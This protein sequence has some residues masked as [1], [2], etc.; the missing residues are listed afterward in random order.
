VLC[1]HPFS[2]VSATVDFDIVNM[3]STPRKVKNPLLTAAGPGF[4]FDNYTENALLMPVTPATPAV[5]RDGE[6]PQT[7]GGAQRPANFT[8][9]PT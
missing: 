4:P 7:L 6:F 1:V 9:C 5:L 3:S 2:N 8:L